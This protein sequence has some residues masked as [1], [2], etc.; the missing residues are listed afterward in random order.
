MAAFVERTWFGISPDGSEHEVKLCIGIPERQ[1]SGDWFADVS[2][3]PLEMNVRRI[4]GID[5]WQALQLAQR[6]AAR[7]VSHFVEDGWKLFWERGG[8]GALPI[9]LLNDGQWSI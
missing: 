6:F 4:F 8:E 9:E 5:S 3:V 7:R 2:L 1:P